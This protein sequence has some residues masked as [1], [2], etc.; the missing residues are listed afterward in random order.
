MKK[1]LHPLLFIAVV[2][3]GGV[4][5][6][7]I[8]KESFEETFPPSGWT[9]NSAD[10]KTAYAHEGTNSVYLSAATDY[11]ITPPLTNA[12]VLTCWTYTTSADPDIII[13]TSP[14]I[15]GPWT[16]VTGSPFSGNTE[17]WNE[18]IITLSS[19]ETIYVR[20]QKSGSGYLYI[21]DVSAEDNGPSPTNIP[22]VLSSLSDISIAISN[23]LS[24]PV[25]ATDTDNDL[26]TLS[27]SNLPPGSGFNTATNAGTVSNTFNWAV[28]APAGVYSVTFFATDKDGSDSKT[29]S[30]T[31]SE[32]PILMITEVADPAGTGGGDYRFVEI[33]NAGNE[34]VDLN[35]GR[36]TLS[37]Q[38]NG[39]SWNDVALSGTL[40][41]GGTWVVAYSSSKFQEAYGVAP[42]QSDNDISGTGDDAY[43]LYSGGDHSSGT[44]MDIYGEFDTDG[45]DTQWEYTDSRAVRNHSATGPAATWIASEWTIVG[46]ATTNDMDP[47]AAYHVPP[48]LSVIGNQGGMEG[49]TISFPISASDLSDGDAISYSAL[50]LPLGAVF[51]NN[52]FTWS[53]A[54]PAGQYLVTFFATDKDGS[55]SETVTITVLEKPRL[56]FSEIADPGDDGG[57]AYRFVELYN[58]GT[59]TIDLSADEWVLSKQVNGGSSW[60]D[61]SLTGS[62]A[63]AS[64]WVIANSA[65][66]FEAAY[67][68]TPDQESSSVSGNGDDVYFLYIGGDHDSG[69][70]VDIYGELDIDGTDTE[71]DYEDSR[72]V[73]NNDIL[74]PNPTW[75]ASEWS[76]T[77]GASTNSMT[78]GEHGPKPQ[79]QGL[80]D[81]FIFP[82][83]EL[84]LIVTAVNTVRTDEIT[85]SATN[86]PV[87][88]SF[89]PATGTNSVSSVFSWNNPASGVYTISFF[90][91][92]DAGT[93][94]KL[95]DLTVSRS[96][97]IDG[98]FYG[99]QPDTIVKLGNGQFWRN[100]GGA[101]ETL[102]SRL[103]K[104]E[105]TVTN[106]LGKDRMFI[107]DVASYTTVEQINVTESML[108][109]TFS[110]LHNGNI[111]QLEDGTVW[112]QINYENVNSSAAPVTAWRWTENG[113]TFIRFLDRYNALIGT[114]EVSKTVVR[115]AGM[116]P[117]EID[118]YFRGWNKGQVFALANGEFWQQTTADSSIETLYRPT[119]TLTNYLQTGT[120]RMYIEGSG[121]PGY[122]EVQQLADVIRTSI[123]GKFYGFGTG[124]FLHLQ[125]GEWWRQTSYNSSAS[126]RSNPEILLWEEDSTWKIE[127]P[128]E[129]R[130]I[131]A[132]QLSVATESSITNNFPGLHYAN[133]YELSNG[134]R[135]MQISFENIRSDADTPIV[136]LWTESGDTHLLARTSRDRTVGTCEVV[137]P[138]ADDDGDRI[139]NAAEIIAG[140]DM[141]DK[142]IFFM[143]TET[144][145]DGN[146]H[147]VLNWN[148]V[149]GR[150]YTILWAASLDDDFLPISVVDAPANSWTDTLHTTGESGFYQIKVSLTE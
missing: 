116:T 1:R 54:A 24:V 150:T 129:G 85:I 6:E 131:T 64:T 76:I 102:S 46:G 10:Q 132:E 112:E 5:A 136:M 43:F 2:L 95:I 93:T 22:P 56:M 15:S 146:G 103:W 75:T 36:W 96:A 53:T 84:S 101:G 106:V 113:T 109:S 97:N 71:W 114:C 130:T 73:R 142:N 34:T 144:Q 30:I 50:N 81:T 134:S 67:G 45:T 17:Q 69:T 119:V 80:E 82:G 63:P 137:N 7:I 124:E 44:L 42:D 52:T 74:E 141:T 25:W 138:D 12:Q 140:T 47:G 110:G 3:G 145:I 19:P 128:D 121:A 105:V 27:A 13:E 40:P 83:T 98:Y 57:D 55:D 104:P 100:T 41:A 122:V 49:G 72:A 86:L 21:D 94:T 92:G 38:V 125:N 143:I 29:I 77:T 107:E 117:T 111:Y 39:D 87:S 135:W 127:M 51:T 48:V 120:W 118:G 89:N 9:Q 79:F 11:L 8:L 133:L 70:L 23:S 26:I 91:S 65:A 4:S 59:N 62:I 147:Y 88:A 32:R 139:I 148:A 108:I 78:P 123:N 16:A 18:H 115:N 68:T 99:W 58:A 37:K 61:L 14:G 20:F 60:G 126:I 28:A 66:D 149:S 31:V 90:A 33:Y 35:A